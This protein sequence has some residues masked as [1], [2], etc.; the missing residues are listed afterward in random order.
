M[1]RRERWFIFLLFSGAL[2]LRLIYML[3]LREHYFFYDNPSADV[4]Y[5]LDWA[6]EI[7]FKDPIGNQAFFGLPLYPYFLAVLYRLSLGHI[8]VIRL[9]Q[10]TLGSLNCVLIYLAGKEMFHSRKIGAVAGILSAVTFTLIYYDWLLMPVT[11]IISLSLIIL[12]SLLNRHILTRPR[13][14]LILGLLLGLA[15]LGDGKFLFITLMASVW[16]YLD[17]RKTAR[18]R[19][20]VILLCGF[21]LVL[22][23]CALRNR[24][25]SGDWILISAQSGLSL[26]AGNNPQATGTFANP[27]YIRPTHEGQDEDQKIVAESIAGKNL[28]PAEV[29]AFWK[30]RALDFILREPG[31]YTALLLRKARLFFT[32]TEYAYDLDLILQRRWKEMLDI[33]GVTLLFALAFIGMAVSWRRRPGSRIALI[34]ILA[35]LMM[36][37]IFFVSSRHRAAII[38]FLI[39]FEAAALGWL[40]TT[41]RQR[42]ILPAAT[43]IIFI[44]FMMT[45]FQPVD[46]PARDLAFIRHAKSGPVYE[47]RGDLA[48]ARSQYQQAIK[49]R[50]GDTNS[51][52]N[53]AN[54][55]VHTGDLQRA[56]QLYQHVL[57]ICSFH[58]DAAFNLAYVYDRLGEYDRALSYYRKVL[59][60]Q[61]EKPDTLYHLARIHARQ[62]H[63]EQARE[64]Y[65]QLMTLQPDLKPDLKKDLAAGLNSCDLE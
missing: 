12:L 16:L 21:L 38:P 29:S 35:Q 57:D 53:L 58:I 49:L 27:E 10:I 52:Y 9:F 22:G 51:W 5:Y 43:A 65:R 28:S 60:F 2:F 33:N 18:L 23:T 1:E 7:A 50:P 15:T 19:Q 48:Q 39:L 24:L 34:F 26:Y 41:V 56:K 64:Y 61:P 17:Q 40:L 55:Y 45:V 32:D 36:S 14:W 11:L 8:E 37:L 6:R 42:R 31:Q 54:T 4:K 3:F 13:Q 30:N 44:A 25:V 20:V 63:C 59:R 62:G 47:Q 46:L